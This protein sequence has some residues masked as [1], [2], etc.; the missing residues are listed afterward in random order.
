M[1]NLRTGDVVLEAAGEVL[2]CGSFISWSLSS[3]YILTQSPGNQHLSKFNW[4][5]PSLKVTSTR[6]SVIIRLSKVRS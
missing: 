1:I 6:Y 4:H 3:L 5:R 2:V